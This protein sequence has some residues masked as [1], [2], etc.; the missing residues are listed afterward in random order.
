MGLGRYE[1]G[2]RAR[3]SRSGT[4]ARANREQDRSEHEAR[5]SRRAFRVLDGVEGAE[6]GRHKWR[7]SR[8]AVAA[9][10]GYGRRGGPSCG[11][12]EGVPPCRFYSRCRRGR[13]GVDKW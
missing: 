11:R 8:R 2:H 6:R 1:R 12:R 13:V 9:A 3:S 4:K 10:C 5:G 7:R